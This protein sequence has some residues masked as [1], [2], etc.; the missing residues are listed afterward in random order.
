MEQTDTGILPAQIG[1]AGLIDVFAAAQPFS[2]LRTHYKVPAGLTIQEMLDHA[3]GG[4][5][6]TAKVFINDTLVD[7][8]YYHRVRPRHGTTVSLRVVPGKGGGG[9]GGKKN[10]L[11]TVLSLAVLAAGAYLGPI[12][13]GSLGF[14]SATAGTIAGG[15][16]S[17]L[18]NLLVGAITSPAAP[19]MN[20]LSP[21]SRVDQ[22][23]TLFIQGARNE[24]LRYGVIPCVLGR[25]RMV[26]PQAASPYTETSG[27]KQYARQLFCW[28]Y[29][30][31][32]LSEI[33]IGETLLT[34]F[35]GV[36]TQHITNGDSA[37]GISLY[38]NIPRQTDLQIFLQA[39]SGA[40]IRTTAED[41]EEIIVDITFPNGLVRFNGNGGLELQEVQFEIAYSPAGANS[42]TTQTYTLNLAQSSAVREPYRFAVSKG[43]Y[44]VRVTRLSADSTSTAVQDKMYWTALRTFTYGKPVNMTGLGLT[45]LRIQATDQ[46][47]GTVDQFNAIVEQ[48]IPDWDAE[49]EEWVSRATSN[50]ASI[51]R[52]ILQGLP[53]AKAV[54]DSQII[55][56]ALQEWHEFCEENGYE[57][58]GIIDYETSVEAVLSEVAAAGRAS[59][60]Q[61]DGK[62]TVVIDRPQDT[63]VQH[64]SPRN[65]WGYSYERALPDIPHAFLVQFINEDKGFIR[66]ER[67]VY[68]DGYSK[69]NATEFEGMEMPGITDPDL[70]WRFGREYIAQLR[71]RPDTHSFYM[72][73]ENIVATRGDLI[74]FAHDVILVGSGSGRI[75]EV[76]DD[77]EET[78][79]VTGMVMDEEFPMVAGK[80]YALRFRLA[81]GV[82]VVKQVVTVPGSDNEVTFV[83]P[84]AL[85][86]APEV[87]DLALYGESGRESM[88]LI[89]KEIEPGNDLTA[90]ITAVNAAPEIFTAGSGAIPDFDSGITI[91]AEFLRP[92]PP[93]I[94]GIQSGEEVQ[95][96]NIDGS[97]TTRMVITLDN[98]NAAPV[99]PFVKIRRVGESLF[100]EA[101]VVSRSPNK[102]V[103]E[104][105]DNGQIYDLRVYYRRAGSVSLGSNVISEPALR[106]GVTFEGTTAA[107]PDVTGFDIT[108]R[109]DSVFLK[110]TRNPAID[111]HHYELRFT[112]NVDTPSWS[113]AV[114]VDNDIGPTITSKSV[115]SAVGSYLI[116]AVDRSDRPSIN[117]AIVTSTIGSLI[118]LNVIEEIEESATWGGTHENTRIDSGDLK[119][120]GS[121]T[122]DDWPMIDDVALWD[123]G[124]AGMA[125]AGIYYFEEIFDL[126]ETY[127]STVSAD[128]EVTGENVLDF[129]DNWESIDGRENW[130]GV[131][132]S[133]YGVVLQVRTTTNSA[134]D[135]DDDSMWTPW[136]NFTIGDYTA[137]ALQFR[138]LLYS[139]ETN[140]T[141]VISH[142]VIKIDMPD[143][144]EASN[145]DI[146]VPAEGMTIS[147][148][149]AFKAPPKGIGLAVDDGEEGDK[150]LITSKTADGF[151]IQFLNGGIGVERTF[152]YVAKGFGFKHT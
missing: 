85:E 52:F 32:Q 50:P 114:P 105:L 102:V 51:Y 116:K 67:A 17:G 131:D 93:V 13:A 3:C 83:T 28:G 74:K 62:W 24:L 146:T 121:D 19:K 144:V 128:I 15:L 147:F 59:R 54:S 100:T 149:T 43:Q 25:H 73:V 11:A 47:N 129:I 142:L 130:D 34:S 76:I 98:T 57:Y 126:S 135:P 110:W 95:I 107:P 23:P 86:G 77:G 79:M 91:P 152:S 112:T 44:D 125:A 118:G 90:R 37:N 82:S 61:V 39:S 5:K 63:P 38:P 132:P 9:G 145:G 141:P 109:G 30:N 16:I 148:P 139:Y 115:P 49:A 122:I 81:T 55:L 45:A 80:S 99:D 84:F 33:K 4:E 31:I 12:V 117:A 123:L 70:I 136:T 87:G 53:N 60:A 10:P 78:P 18:G 2:V 7:P 27:G 1:H 21:E 36:E 26:P 42:W 133:N 75:K 92:E 14:A 89:I 106:N 41:I 134:P 40:A 137:R 119:L 111:L 96:R 56:P 101:A 66:D 94:T 68:D 127:T 151:H 58:N 108:V 143:R 150:Y 113:S 35:S 104:G 8:K 22:S 124:A 120:G 48:I 72:D 103:I 65:S 69:S 138:V 29:G 6:I 97:I 71:L 46:L 88:D 64:V 140:I 20:E